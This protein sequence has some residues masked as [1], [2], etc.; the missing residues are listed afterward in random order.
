MLLP[1][2]HAD[3]KTKWGIAGTFFLGALTISICTV[4]FVWG[5]LVSV[6]PITVILLCTAEFTTALIVVCLPILRPLIIKKKKVAWPEH[7]D[8]RIEEALKGYEEWSEFNK[9]AG[10]KQEML[11]EVE[12]REANVA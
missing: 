1:Q 2:I 6:F 3:R 12:I 7:N 5:D 11:V 9:S 4:R 10:S 8:R